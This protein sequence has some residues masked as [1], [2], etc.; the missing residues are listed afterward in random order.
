MSPPIARWLSE[1][2]LWFSPLYLGLARPERLIGCTRPGPLGL[3]GWTLVDCVL[4]LRSLESLQLG[5][6]CLAEAPADLLLRGY[7]TAFAT[8][9]TFCSERNSR[10]DACC[11]FRESPQATEKRRRSRDGPRPAGSWRGRSPRSA[12]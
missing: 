3:A 6:V 12:C 11:L 2:L 9:E 1:I 10:E 5:A 4:P 8:Q 7:S